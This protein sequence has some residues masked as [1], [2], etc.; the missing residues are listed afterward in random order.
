VLFYAPAFAPAREFGI[1][2]ATPIAEFFFRRVATDLDW[3]FVRGLGSAL[4]EVL[5]DPPTAAPY[6]EPAVGLE[7]R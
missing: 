6:T 4:G 1:S 2:L 5:N 3:R 7:R